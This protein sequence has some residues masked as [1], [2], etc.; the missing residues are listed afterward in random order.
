ML[1]CN[2]PFSYSLTNE[3]NARKLPY[4][5]GRVFEVLNQKKEQKIIESYSV[6]QTTLEQIFVQLA[7]EDEEAIRDKRGNNQNN[8]IQPPTTRL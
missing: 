8:A 7:G 3:A 6:S 5:L 4:N 2:L 1:F